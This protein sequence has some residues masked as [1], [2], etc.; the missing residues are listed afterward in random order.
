MGYNFLVFRVKSGHLEITEFDQYECRGDNAVRILQL[1]IA[2]APDSFEGRSG[3][4]SFTDWP[5]DASLLQSFDLVFSSTKHFGEH[6]PF[7]PFPCPYSLGWPQIGV[8]DGN[9]LLISFLSSPP[10][11]ESPKAF[12]IGANM[13]HSR[14]TLRET[15]QSFPELF[16][17]ELMEWNR[18][19]PEVRLQSQSRYVHLSD[20]RRY[21][22][23]IDCQGGGYSGRLRWLIASGRPVFVVQRREVEFWHDFMV[24]WKHYIPVRE[25]LGDLLENHGIIEENPGLYGEIA[26]H[27]QEF[28]GE[29]LVLEKMIKHVVDGVRSLGH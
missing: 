16:D 8:P 29:N 1:A 24:P 28:A 2:A 18:D 10:A 21:K 14:A 5:P 22:Y 6:S 23:L 17:V 27:A 25:D 12:W 20:H 3:C 15:A 11:P 13:H 9:G 4:V 19:N 26:M 7:L